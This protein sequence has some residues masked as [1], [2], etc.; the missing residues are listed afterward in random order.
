MKQRILILGIGN[1]VGAR[2]AEAL[3]A[4]DWAAPVAQRAP[5]A[6]AEA[7]LDGFDAV[8]N[9]TMGSPAAIL[10]GARSLFATLTRSGARVRVVHLS[11]M[12]VYGAFQGEADEATP[13]R[14]DL[15][16]YGAAQIEAESLASQYPHTV[17]LRP[18][19]EYG[20]ACPQ[21]SERIARLLLEH[22]LGDL[23]VAGDGYCNLLYVDDL[24]AAVLASLRLPAI[25]G[26]KFN[27]AMRSPPT[28][29]EYLVRFGKALGAIPISRLGGRRLKLETKLLAPFLKIMEITASRSGL[30]RALIPPPIPPSL[31]RLCSQQIT[32]N[33]AQAE[34]C[35]Q[36]DWMPL[37]EGLR[38]AA[39][40]FRATTG[41]DA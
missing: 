40:A 19:C 23:G 21:W 7:D 41:L 13:L 1:F 6:F 2:V 28:W 4:S 17:T 27:L 12:S 24:V 37:D 26:L 10:T 34:R 38:R 33:V 30:R 18:G 31:L 20:P 16:A 32:L 35:L 29:N 8:F 3:E 39:A 14:P 11:S 22:R 15:G 25:E 5:T 9:G 36:I